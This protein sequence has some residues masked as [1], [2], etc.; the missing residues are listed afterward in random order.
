[1]YRKFRANGKIF[2]FKLDINPISNEMDYHIWIRHLVEP[3]TVIKA[4]FNF[5]KERYNEKYERYE[6][7]SK[8]YNLT[9]YYFYLRKDE[10]T[11]IT[12]FQ[13]V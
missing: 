11:I 8:K 13:G 1:M 9:I 10:V 4:F 2:R 3:E 12:A 6:A 5:D 7:F